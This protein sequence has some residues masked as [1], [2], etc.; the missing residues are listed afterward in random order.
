MASRMSETFPDGAEYIVDAIE[1]VRGVGRRLHFVLASG[2]SVW[3]SIGDEGDTPERRDM[4]ADHLKTGH[5][6]MRGVRIGVQSG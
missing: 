1:D 5:R 2:R 3:V 4:I 6:Y